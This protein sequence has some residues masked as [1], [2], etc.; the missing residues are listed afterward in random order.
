MA[1]QQLHGDVVLVIGASSGMG[2]AIAEALSNEGHRV[3]G[4]SRKA[5]FQ[6]AEPT[7]NQAGGFL[8]MLPLDV[9]SE[10]SVQVGLN[11]VQAQEGRIDILINC[12]GY[13]LAGA[14]EDTTTEEAYQEFNTNFFGAH[15]VCRNIAPIM[16]EQG[17]GLIINISSVAGLV[18]IPFQSF[19]SASKYALDA[20]TEALR[21]E[22]KPFGIK[23]ALISPGDTKTD[24]TKNR[25]FAKGSSGS[26]YATTFERSVARMIKDEQSGP[27]PDGIVR[28]VQR[29]IRSKNPPVRIVVGPVNKLFAFVL[30][31]LPSRLI[32]YIVGKMYS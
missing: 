16:R 4:T 28:A 30:R 6:N 5:V 9:C 23:V 1:M 3:Y 13:A 26:V 17:G 8:K 10:E 12:A 32:S 21:L 29:I 31:I 11:Y 18:A 19:Y 27:P 24:F 20:M 7:R 14:I 2:K 25:Y 15:R 22:L